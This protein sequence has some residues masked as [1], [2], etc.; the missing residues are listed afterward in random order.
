MAADI[1]QI[2]SSPWEAPITGEFSVSFPSPE[3]AM[4]HPREESCLIVP[5]LEMLVMLQTKCINAVVVRLH[6]P[7]ES[8]SLSLSLLAG[9]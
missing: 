3:A 5:F 2:Q 8:V 4:F 9:S 1:S 6:S 7:L